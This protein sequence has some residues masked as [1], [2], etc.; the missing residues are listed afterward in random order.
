MK[1]CLVLSRY[2]VMDDASGN[3]IMQVRRL[4]RDSL[5]RAHAILEPH[6]VAVKKIHEQ[7]YWDHNVM[8]QCY[9]VA[10]EFETQEDYVMAKLLVHDLLQQLEQE[11]LPPW[12]RR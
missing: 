10:L 8:G 9:G 1:N 11:N 12:A 3:E 6:K 5:E 7:T 4:V 2:I